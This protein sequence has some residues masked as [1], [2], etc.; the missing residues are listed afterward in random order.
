MAPAHAFMI[1]SR[2]WIHVN[3]VCAWVE[4]T[5]CDFFNWEPFDL[6][7]A[8]F[9]WRELPSL[10]GSLWSLIPLLA[11]EKLRED[12]WDVRGREC[13]KSKLLIYISFVFFPFP[14]KR[15]TRTRTG[16]EWE[17]EWMGDWNVEWEISLWAAYKIALWAGLVSGKA[18]QL[19]RLSRYGP[20]T[21]SPINPEINYVQS[22][23]QGAFKHG[24]LNSTNWMWTGFELSYYYYR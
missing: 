3:G 2:Q 20:P 9:A 8:S 1:A 7:L 4:A 14:G 16:M 13:Q 18:L 21:I 5:F 17:W 23:V 22:E 6:R 12:G 15:K 19:T 10:C 11:G 24:I